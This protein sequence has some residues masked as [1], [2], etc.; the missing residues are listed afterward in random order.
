DPDNGII[1]GTGRIM[2]IDDE[3]V[4]RN[5]ASSMLKELGYEVV[6]FEDPVA[7]VEFFENH[8]SEIGLVIVDMVMPRMNGRECFEALK[9]RDP[10]IP[11]ILS[12]GYGQDTA[13][14]ETMREGLS[15]FVQKPYRLQT[16][17]N[18]VAAAIR[19]TEASSPP[20][21]G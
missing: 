17:S 19:S 4:V 15:G 5:L 9:K 7:A 10:G 21:Q 12:S 13:I 2:V 11:V 18:A 14:Q 20:K 16:L 1:S 8:A 6:T 3:S